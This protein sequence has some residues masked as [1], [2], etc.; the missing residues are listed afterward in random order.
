MRDDFAA[1][2]LTHRR[3]DNVITIGAL[4]ASGYTGKTYIVVDDLDPTL[5]EYRARYGD[6]VLT[7][8]KAAVAPDMDA[9]D[10]VQGLRGVVYARN[11][12]WALARS[13]GV[14]YF[15]ELDDDYNSFLYR[16]KGVQ[17]GVDNVHGWTIRNIDRVFESMVDFVDATGCATLAMAQGGDFI[18]GADQ[19]TA[20]LTRKVMNSFV[21]DVKRPFQFMGRLNEDVNAYVTEGNRG[22]LFFTYWTLQLNQTQTQQATGGLTELYLDSGTYIKSFYTV[23]YSPSCASVIYSPVM[24]RFHHSIRW[25][26]A[27]PKIV[28][29]RHRKAERV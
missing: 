1:F 14:R 11:A 16:T 25:N 10:N 13:V 27:V 22:R 21:C 3:P 23:M 20:R 26:A 5:D 17:N 7:F 19:S 6:A 28:H 4:A 24:R 2:I 15:I 9:G 29:E 18:G 12:L 8:S